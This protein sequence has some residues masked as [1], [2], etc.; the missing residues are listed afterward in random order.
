MRCPESLPCQPV[1][2]LINRQGLAQVAFDE[3]GIGKTL[4]EG[5]AI[6]ASVAPH[7]SVAPRLLLRNDTLKK[8]SYYVP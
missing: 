3:L 1:E 2:L 8:T 6:G 7:A 4:A 5:F